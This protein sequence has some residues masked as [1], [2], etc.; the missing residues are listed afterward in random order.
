MIRAMSESG[1][2]PAADGPVRELFRVT[3][4]LAADES[5]APPSIAQRF[6]GRLYTLDQ[7]EQRGVRIA[8]RAAWF[9]AAGRDWQLRLEPAV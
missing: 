3:A 2:P 8:N 1:L 7:L 9:V 4:V 5:P 6:D